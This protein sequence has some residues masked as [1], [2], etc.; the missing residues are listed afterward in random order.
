M[1]ISGTAGVASDGRKARDWQ[2]GGGAQKY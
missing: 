2:Y 1:P